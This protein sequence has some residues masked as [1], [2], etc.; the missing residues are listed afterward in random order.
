M[1]GTKNDTA[2]HVDVAAYIWPVVYYFYIICCYV[3]TFFCTKDKRMVIKEWW[4]WQLIN[5]YTHCLFLKIDL[6]KGTVVTVAG[7]GKQGND[8]EGGSIGTSQCISSPWD[9][10]AGPPPG[11]YS[12]L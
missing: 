6:E 1:L 8:K 5:V 10:T 3:C 2:M 9:V 7:N 11:L 4:C 12:P